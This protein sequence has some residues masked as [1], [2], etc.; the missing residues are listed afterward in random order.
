MQVDGV[1]SHAAPLA[2]N[3][4]SSPVLVGEV[5]K[6]V[7]AVVTPTAKAD[8]EKVLAAAEQLVAAQ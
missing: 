7:L 4:T 1:K 8:D 6:V 5:P 3:V 2:P